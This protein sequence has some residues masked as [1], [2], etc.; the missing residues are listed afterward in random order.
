[1][2]STREYA[3]VRYIVDDVDAAIVFYTT[4]LGFTVLTSAG[5]GLRRRGP[6]TAEGVAVRPG[7]FRCPRNP[8]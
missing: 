8:R 5:P 4:H 7:E 3:S 6:R 2:T 1:M